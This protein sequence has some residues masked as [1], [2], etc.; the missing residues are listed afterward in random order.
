MGEGVRTGDYEVFVTIKKSDEMARALS[1]SKI[2][3]EFK[4]NFLSEGEGVGKRSK[5]EL[6]WRA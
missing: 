5:R 4:L 2:S 1:A 3:F 6:L